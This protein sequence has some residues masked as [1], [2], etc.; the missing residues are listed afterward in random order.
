MFPWHQYLLAILFIG[1]GFN[2]FR[3]PKMYERV[4]PTYIPAHSS[5]VLASGIIEM[6][7]G[8]MLITKESQA[9]GAWGIIALLILF[10]PIH[11]YMLQNKDAS[12]QLPKWVLLLR[13]PVQVVLMYW[14]T[15]YLK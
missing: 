15:L 3:V 14:A 1:S 4:M 12:L 2:H 13:L 7:F 10:I 6:I 8:F 9:I 5:L 11:I